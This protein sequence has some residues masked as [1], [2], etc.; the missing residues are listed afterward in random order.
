MV[1]E[2]R[3]DT[4]RLHSDVFS[5]TFPACILPIQWSESSFIRTYEIKLVI[6]YKMVAIS[7]VICIS[8]TCMLLVFFTLTVLML[9]LVLEVQKW[10]NGNFDTVE[11]CLSRQLGTKGSPKLQNC[12]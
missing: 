7:N 3:M 5:S 6:I 10:C 9:V 1:K 4:S 8:T 11:P 12:L 2:D